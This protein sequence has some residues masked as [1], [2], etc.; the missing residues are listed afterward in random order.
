MVIGLGNSGGF[1]GSNVW[2]TRE[3]P[4]YVTGV[5][6]SMSLMI[7]CGICSTVYFFDLR[8]E[9]RRRDM[10]G[11]DYR[12]TEEADDLDNMGDDHPTWRYTL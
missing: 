6:V 1:I 2:L 9:N 12:Y 10:G 3:A 8:A 4:T 11:R 5:S 7:F